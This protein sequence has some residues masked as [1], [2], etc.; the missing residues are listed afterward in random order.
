MK[1][2][3]A[4]IFAALMLCGS[5]VGCAEEPPAPDTEPPATVT[6]DAPVVTDPP[7]TTVYPDI[8]EEV[9]YESY[10]FNIFVN[11]HSTNYSDFD[12][13]NP[14]Y[15]VVN[16]AAFKR[17]MLVEETLNISIV[18]FFQS[19]S[20]FKTG[21]GSE[22][23]GKDYTAGDSSYDL[24]SIGAWQGPVVAQNKYAMNLYEVPYIDLERPWWDQRAASDLG[25]GG[26]MYFTTGE[27]G[28]KDNL[29]T[30]CIVFSK[31]LAEEKGIKDIYELVLSRKW[32]WDK[33]EEYTRMVSE[34]VNGD[35]VM[36]INDRFGL[37]CWNDAFQASF[38]A[39]RTGIGMVNDEGLL[40]LT[41]YSERNND[42]ANR[43]CELM[44][45]KNVSLNHINQTGIESSTIIST[46]F[47]NGQALFLTTLF[48]NLILLRDSDMDYG[49]IP[50]PMY[51]EEQGEYGGYVGPT[52]SSF[53][54]I[55]TYVEDLDRTGIVTELLAYESMQ[56]L[57]PAYYEYTLKGREVRDDESIECLEIIFANRSYDPGILYEIGGYTGK[58]TNMMKSNVNTFQQIYNMS[59]RAANIGIKQ[60]NNKLVDKE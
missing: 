22:I 44:F 21:P 4:L 12:L 3:F 58:L 34:D 27:I 48:N 23:M 56:L 9:D 20:A 18:P 26:K 35:D 28:L 33:F 13:E 52:Y 5:F 10:Q 37:L 60:V 39:A 36:D 55:E 15:D 46:M 40:E 50:L 51:N 49:I 7:V 1:K 2:I 41:L 8:P 38:G 45:D 25:I 19:G 53:W 24:C 14:G 29:A 59:E 47:P 6:T 31:S 32:T 43:I 54:A 30:H 16:E 17:N 57:T 42:L 11:V